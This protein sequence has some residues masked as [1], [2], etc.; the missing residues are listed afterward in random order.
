MG[1]CIL[2]LDHP[3]IER[4]ESFGIEGSSVHS[5]S[6]PRMEAGRAHDNVQEHALRRGRWWAI[7]GPQ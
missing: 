4:R 3:R 7:E 6:V 2:Q 1:V 5:P